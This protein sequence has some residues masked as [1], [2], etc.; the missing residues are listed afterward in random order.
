MEVWDYIAL[1][2]CE[3]GRCKKCTSWNNNQLCY[4]LETIG[5]WAERV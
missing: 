3:E 4:G 5:T 1:L 2:E